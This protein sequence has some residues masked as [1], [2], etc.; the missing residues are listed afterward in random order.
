MKIKVKNLATEV[1]G[2]TEKNQG[3]LTGSTGFSG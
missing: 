3:D 2:D 1:T